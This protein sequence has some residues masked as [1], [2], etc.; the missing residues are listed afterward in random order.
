MA[1]KL[2]IKPQQVTIDLDED[3]VR[4]IT[5]T[6]LTSREISILVNRSHSSINFRMKHLLAKNP[7]V[8]VHSKRKIPAGK[9]F[10][11]AYTY[12]AL[13]AHK[14]VNVLNRKLTAARDYLQAAFFGG[15]K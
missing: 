6:P 11:V 9:G 15:S 3:I 14:S 13:D 4:V 8:T 1:R 12:V 5:N 2:A 7:K 10:V